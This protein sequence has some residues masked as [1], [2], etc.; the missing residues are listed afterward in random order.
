MYADCIGDM[1]AA[2][3]QLAIIHE[4]LTE[5]TDIICKYLDPKLV[6][7]TMQ[8]KRALTHDDVQ[9]IE[10]KKVDSDQA[11]EMLNILMKKPASAYDIFVETLRNE[12]RKDLYGHF[13]ALESKHGYHGRAGR[14]KSPSNSDTI[15]SYH[16]RMY[17]FIL[18]SSKIM[19]LTFNIIAISRN[20]S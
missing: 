19:T 1:A 10:S 3:N 16:T 12:G 5:S 15:S 2:I 4:I 20:R 17:K 7:R 9:R 18:I 11:A 13:K 6:L 8:A 14:V